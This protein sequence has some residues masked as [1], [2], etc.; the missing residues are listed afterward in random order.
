[1]NRMLNRQQGQAL[2]EGALALLVL[3]AM[4]GAVS[5]LFR[6]QDMAL[7]A[8]HA[9][10][11]LAFEH[12]RNPQTAIQSATVARTF[13]KEQR[14]HDRQ[15][16]SW[17]SEDSVRWR[18]TENAH[19]MDGA[20]WDSHFPGTAKTIW[21]ELGFT[22]Y[23]HARAEVTVD[24]AHNNSERLAR[25]FRDA[26]NLGSLQLTRQTSILTG[27]A[28]HADSPLQTQS[29][30]GQSF[31]LWRSTADASVSLGRRTT[32]LMRPVDSVW[33]RGMPDFDWLSPW[34]RHIPTYLQPYGG[35]SHP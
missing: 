24:L 3:I 11:A 8:M 1:M 14:W 30:I 18:I 22:P 12:M 16:N 21:T 4:T 33:N 15:G 31:N 32:A 28:G 6:W 23:G 34:A 7:Q 29:R 19:F 2:A 25:F 20:R 26:G 35:G 17:L 27:S 9:S 13:H 5:V 10:R